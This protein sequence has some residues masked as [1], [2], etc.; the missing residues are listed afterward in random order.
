VISNLLNNAAKYTEPGGRIELTVTRAGAEAVVGVR[1]TGLGIAPE[2]LPK[3]F[4]MFTQVDASLHR[5]QGGMGVGLTIVRRLVEMHGGRIEARSEGP[6]KGSEFL[7]HLPIAD[8]AP[9]D[10]NSTIPEADDREP[11][12][13]IR[14]LVVDDV[15]DSADSLSRLLTLDG[16]DVHTAYDGAQALA[17]AA[18]FPPDVILLDLGL[19]DRNGF[20]I[21]AELRAD[22]SFRDVMLVALTGWGQPEDRRRSSEAGFDHHL[23]KPVEVDALRNI[24]AV[25]AQSARSRGVAASTGSQPRPQG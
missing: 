3:V 1:D 20:E 21:A 5:A 10:S 12:G 13:A 8:V 14:V 23:V 22:P 7:V 19:P 15:R 11:A 25:V 18:A 4:E 6:G 24:L 2:M 16:H 9:P 17:E